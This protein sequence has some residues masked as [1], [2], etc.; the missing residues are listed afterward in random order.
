M[1]RLSPST[2]LSFAST[3]IVLF[4][5]SSRTVAV[6]SF[7]IGGSLIGV[8]VTYTVALSVPPLL[9]VIE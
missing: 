2:S 7:A 9:S 3:S 6:S 1:V 8:T 4:V 5:E